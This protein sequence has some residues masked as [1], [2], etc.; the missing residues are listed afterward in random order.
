MEVIERRMPIHP[1]GSGSLETND[2][3]SVSL[4]LKEVDSNLLST[5]PKTTIWSNMVAIK[6]NIFIWRDHLDCLPTT[7]NLAKRGGQKRSPKEVLPYRIGRCA[8]CNLVDETEHHLF[9]E[10][11]AAKELTAH[12]S[13]WA[14]P[15]RF[16]SSINSIEDL[17][18]QQLHLFKCKERE[19]LEAISRALIWTICSSRN[20]LLF[21]GK[22]KTNQMLIME[23][24][25]L[26]YNR[27]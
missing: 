23:V 14:A 11:S 25:G 6:T 9:V 17:L 8:L 20:E 26:A 27:L 21:E 1:N 24:N 5:V 13:L 18:S 3:F 2:I 16:P 15:P 12:I 19:M 7:T 10:C 4:L 22:V